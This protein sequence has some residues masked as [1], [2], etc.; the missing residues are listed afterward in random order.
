MDG[1]TMRRRGMTQDLEW[2]ARVE[3][4]AAHRMAVMQGFNEGICYHFTLNVPGRPGLFLAIP[5]GLHWAEVKASDFLV[6]DYQ[7][8][9]V[10]GEG[11]IE[12]TAWCIHAPIHRLKPDANCLL[13]T[14]TML[15][16]QRLE[17]MGQMSAILAPSISYDEEYTGLA[18]EPAEGERLAAILEDGKTILFMA[19]HGVMVTGRTIA[20]AYDRLYYLERACQ[21]QVYAYMTGQKRR[22]VRQDVIATLRQQVAFG[23][24]GG[25]VAPK[26]GSP[27]QRHFDALKRVLQ[28]RGEGDYEA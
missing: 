20:E 13:H 8:R 9:V 24:E 10:E 25:G 17:A 27:A 26:G 18:H 1:R 3:L 14:L 11:E 16:D 12:L 5:Y 4:A 28:R 6:C 7:G 21:T 22:R 19:S 15:Q 2:Q 23:L